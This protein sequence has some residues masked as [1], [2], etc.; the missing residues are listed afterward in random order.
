MRIV[1]KDF[2]KADRVVIVGSS[3]I[4]KPED[5]YLKLEDQGLLYNQQTEA[6][7]EQGA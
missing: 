7:E 5:E 3:T 6:V 1:D 2:R 4:S